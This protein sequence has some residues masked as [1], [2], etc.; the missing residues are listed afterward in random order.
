M[1]GSSARARG[2]IDGLA[3]GEG[4]VDGEEAFERE[5]GLL[6]EMEGEHGD[7]VGEDEGYHGADDVV[8]VAGVGVADVGAEVVVE[9]F[10]EDVVDVETVADAAEP[11]ERRPGKDSAGRPV[12]S[13]SAMLAAAAMLR[14]GRPIQNWA[15]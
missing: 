15:G 3:P 10:E 2:F 5:D 13:T 1:G 7:D 14:Q 6:E 9:G 11:A 12:R 8:V 4:G